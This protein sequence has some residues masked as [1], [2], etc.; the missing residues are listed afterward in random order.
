MRQRS[1]ST[2]PDLGRQCPRLLCMHTLS[3]CIML[4]SMNQRQDRCAINTLLAGDF[5]VSCTGR[6]D[7]NSGLF[8]RYVYKVT[9]PYGVPPGTSIR[10]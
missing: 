9:T 7:R 6:G 4:V 1:I 2:P 10:P 5:A 8:V 3:G